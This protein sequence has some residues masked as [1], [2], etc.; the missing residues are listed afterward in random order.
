MKLV[1]TLK[2]IPMNGWMVNYISYSTGKTVYSMKVVEGNIIFT[3]GAK[4]TREEYFEEFIGKEYDI[5]YVLSHEEALF[6][7]IAM[8]V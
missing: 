2:D 7:I 3:G 5:N 1:K 6:Y 8:E 4:Y